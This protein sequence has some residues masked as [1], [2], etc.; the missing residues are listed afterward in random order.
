M[1]TPGQGADGPQTQS[2]IAALDAL[3]EVSYDPE[4][5]ADYQTIAAAFSPDDYR[6]IIDL[7]WRHQFNSE[8]LNF[9][10]ELRELQEHVC[11]RIT[12]A[13]DGKE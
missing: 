7:A 6:A 3:K 13:S 9:K 10:R 5:L 4:I 8:R 2:P 12:L 1:N 11:S